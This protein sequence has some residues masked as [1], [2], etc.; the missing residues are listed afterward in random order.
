VQAEAAFDAAFFGNVNRNNTDQPSPNQFPPKTDTTTIT[1]G[2][3]KLLVTGATVTLTHNQVRVENRPNA[4]LRW[5]PVWTDNF[6]AE[7]RQPLL[8]NFGIDFNRAQINIRKLQ[9]QANE[10]AFRAR[11]INILDQTEQAYWTLVAARRDVVTSAETLAHAQNTLDQVEARKDFDAY[12]TLVYR[13][14]TAVKAR[15]FDYINVK[16]RVRNAE[17]QLLNLLN[18]PELP[19]SADYEILPEDNPML[20]PVVRDRFK[21]VE[22]ALERRPELVQARDSV[23]IA[24]L[25]LG[26]AKNQALPRL[27]AVYRMTVNGI[28]G[29][30]DRAWDQMTGGNFT[31]NFVGIEFAWN[32]GE[33]AERAGIRIAAL[34]QSQAVLQYK[35]SLDDVITDCRVALRN[36][37]TNF[38]QIGPSYQ[39]VIAAHENL[40]S[41]QERQERKSPAELDTV[42]SAQVNL[43]DARRGFLQAVTQYNTGIIDVERAKGTLLEYDNVFLGRQ[44]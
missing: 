21:I 17:D 44:R 3:R 24:R 32:F 37:E 14:Q 43:A 23:D 9:R 20:T 42:L 26:I 41:L 38:N 12:Q 22:T 11:V 18:D 7:L 8:R 15:E 10:E 33:R 16:N 1:G 35:R 30:A 6:A 28:G 31:D 4:A 13:S 19:L 34:Q 25:Q 5:N 2:I 36:L 39:A 27:D 40:R 29:N